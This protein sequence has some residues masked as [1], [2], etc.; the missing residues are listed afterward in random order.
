MTR[1]YVVKVLKCHI[2]F[3]AKFQQPANCIDKDEIFQSVKY[4]PCTNRKS[5]NKVDDQSSSHKSAS[6]LLEQSNFMEEI[7]CKKYGIDGVLKLKI[8]FLYPRLPLSA[9]VIARYSSFSFR[10]NFGYYRF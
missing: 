4:A 6:F 1:L 3:L 5:R 9:A 10:S 8:E 2:Q 7:Y